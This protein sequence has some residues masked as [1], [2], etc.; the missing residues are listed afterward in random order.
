MNTVVKESPA[1]YFEGKAKDADQAVEELVSTFFRFRVDLPELP[2]A[3]EEMSE[4]DLL[5]AAEATGVFRFLDGE[6]ED[7]YRP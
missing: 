6:G 2:I 5:L 1:L 3:V 7:L 4:K